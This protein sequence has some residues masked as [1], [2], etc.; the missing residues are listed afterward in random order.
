MKSC[1]YCKCIYIDDD[2]PFLSFGEHDGNVKVSFVVDIIIQ[3]VI[4]FIDDFYLR[5]EAILK[6]HAHRT[7]DTLSNGNIVRKRTSRLS[8][9]AENVKLSNG[10]QGDEQTVYIYK[11]VFDCI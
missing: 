7:C 8:R 6:L 10:G 3:Y 1:T 9:N 5:L 2:I 4:A 11:V